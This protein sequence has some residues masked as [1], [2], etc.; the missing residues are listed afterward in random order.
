[1]NSQKQPSGLLS[2]KNGLI[3]LVILATLT[4]FYKCDKLFKVENT[5]KGVEEMLKLLPKEAQKEIMKKKRSMGSVF[6]DGKFVTAGA[7]ITSNRVLVRGVEFDQYIQNA[8]SQ[9]KKVEI[10]FLDNSLARFTRHI[11]SDNSLS[12]QMAVFEIDQA[13]GTPGRLN[14]RNTNLLKKMNAF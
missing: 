1:M 13:I 2:T 7:P 6:L 5:E 14:E 3:V 10:R 12:V 8:L 11:V 4:V 9:N